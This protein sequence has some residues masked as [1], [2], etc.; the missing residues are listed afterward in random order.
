MDWFTS[1][2]INPVAIVTNV[3]VPFA[4]ASDVPSWTATPPEAPGAIPQAILIAGRPYALDPDDTTSGHDG[5]W[6]A[7]S[8]D[9]RRYKASDLPQLTVAESN[10]LAIPPIISSGNYGKAWI[11][12]L[13]ASGAWAGHGNDVAV[14][15]GR[16]WLFVPPVAGMQ[17]LVRS[18]GAFYHYSA[19]GAWTKGLGMPSA[20]TVDAE[21]LFWPYG[22]IV[23]SRTLNTPPT[24]SSRYAYIVGSSPT[25]AWAGYAGYV[26]IGPENGWTFLPPVVGAEIW[27]RAEARYVRYVSGIWSSDA[28]TLPGT[29]YAADPSALSLSGNSYVYAIGTAPTVVNT[30][31]SGLTISHAARTTGNMIRLRGRFSS[32]FLGVGSVALFVD[33]A[34]T[35]AQWLPVA[36]AS[37]WNGSAD[38]AKTDL[39]V[40]EFVVLVG[41][42]A[43]HSYD[44]RFGSAIATPANRHL[45]L[46]E[47]SVLT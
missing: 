42:A 25:G 40:F 10:T 44:I 17:L 19:A 21:S 38:T 7:V 9:G 23:E 1:G 8:A 37:Y 32:A 18:A 4:S 28:G 3:A 27:C 12:P 15:T 6:T 33:G 2:R 43:T 5:I 13:A 16:G 34:S 46:E 36:G 35:A 24:G 26:A 14:S 39:Y 47:T 41:D 45:T 30:A 20:G 29:R 31:A 22:L 11:I